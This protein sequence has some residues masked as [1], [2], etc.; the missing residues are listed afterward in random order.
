[1]QSSPLLSVGLFVYN[2][3]KFLEKA[4]D[5]LLAQTFRDFELIISDNASTDAT[6]RICRAYAERDARVQYYRNAENLGAGWNLRRVYFLARGKYF[7]WAAHDDFCEPALFERCVDALERDPQLVLVQSKVRVIDEKDEFVEDYEW[8]MRTDSRS[9][10]IRFRD[11]LL[12]DHM[13][14]QIFGV[15]RMHAL[16]QLPAQGSYVNS[17][18]VLLAQLGMLGRFYEVPDR[19]FVNTRHSR[20]SSQTVPVRVKRTGWRLTKRYGT[21]PCPEWWDPKLTKK[22]TF[23]EWRQLREYTASVY[24]S[25]LGI[26]DKIRAYSL[27]PLWI[28]KHLRRMLKDLLIVADQLLYNFQNERAVKREARPAAAAGD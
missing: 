19:L 15:I 2:G 24:N 23:P 3:E 13:C 5:C 7:K 11:L 17:D 26:I 18:G 9:P 16:K 10:V 22:L 28:K 8:P 12:N 6:E 27:L 21:L 14:F 25:P 20:Q 1:M 4:L